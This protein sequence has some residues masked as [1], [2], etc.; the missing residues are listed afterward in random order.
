MGGSDGDELR[1]RVR[2]SLAGIAERKHESAQ[3]KGSNPTH[4]APPES[5]DSQHNRFLMLPLSLADRKEVRVYS[6]EYVLAG[7]SKTHRINI[8]APSAKAALDELAG[9]FGS[10]LKEFHIQP[11][12]ESSGGKE[13]SR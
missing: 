7:D 8:T 6:V 5:S 13:D 2:L 10:E 3:K 1:T 9:R 11:T 4:S 12:D